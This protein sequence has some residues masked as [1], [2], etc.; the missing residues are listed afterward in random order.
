MHI[1]TGL[2]I[3]A[4]LGRKTAETEGMGAGF[5]G[6]RN[7]LEIRHMIPGRM[8]LYAPVIRENTELGGR[9]ERELRKADGID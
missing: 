3:S 8:R 7:I 9:L 5:K 6:F 1:I 4:F 2:L